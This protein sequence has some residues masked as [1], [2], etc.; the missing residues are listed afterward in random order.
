VLDSFTSDPLRGTALVRGHSPAA[1]MPTI[2]AL[3]A[4]FTRR[5]VVTGATVKVVGRQAFLYPR[6]GAWQLR[7]G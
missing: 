4:L 6:G 7:I 1:K 5:L 3:P 2:I